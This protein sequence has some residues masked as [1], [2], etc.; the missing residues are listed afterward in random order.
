MYYYNPCFRD[1]KT[2]DRELYNLAKGPKASIYKGYL[3]FEYRSV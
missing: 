1:E 3:G 2:K